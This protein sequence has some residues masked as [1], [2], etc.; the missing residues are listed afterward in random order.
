MTQATT[1]PV[2]AVDHGKR[3]LATDGEDGHIWRGVPTLLLTTGRHGGELECC[4]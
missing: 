3:Y 2:W 1:L 4:L